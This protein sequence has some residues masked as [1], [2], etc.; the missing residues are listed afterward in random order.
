ML[1]ENERGEEHECPYRGLWGDGASAVE[2]KEEL[3]ARG[4]GECY[5]LVGELRELADWT[6]RTLSDRLLLLVERHRT[7]NKAGLHEL[8]HRVS[9]VSASA[10]PAA[11]VGLYLPR[12]RT[13]LRENLSFFWERPLRGGD[14]EGLGIDAVAQ[15]LPVEQET[16]PVRNIPQVGVQLRHWDPEVTLPAGSYDAIAAL[17]SYGLREAEI[18]EQQRRLLPAEESPSDVMAILD[19][20]GLKPISSGP[21]GPAPLPARLLMNML[22]AVPRGARSRGPTPVNTPTLTFRAGELREWCWPGSGGQ[23]SSGARGWRS[24]LLGGLFALDRLRVPVMEKLSWRPVSIALLLEQAADMTAETPVTV[25]FTLLPDGGQGPRV[26]VPTLR[27]LQASARPWRAYL[28]LAAHWYSGP[29]AEGAGLGSRGG[30][31]RW[32][33]RP[34]VAEL[35]ADEVYRL[36]FPR[37]GTEGG[38]LRKRRI[39]SKT[40]LYDLRDRGLLTLGEIFNESG[41]V[42]SWLVS[43]R[44]DERALPHLLAPVAGIA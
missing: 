11:E 29:K 31:G 34:P 14:V 33:V 35:S 44:N 9:V 37:D 1:E 5:R 18:I 27:E 39:D 10:D 2:M 6:W 38:A 36:C 40:T 16:A 23:R 19:E 30:V 8:E 26:H 12:Q 25:T 28:S 4:C 42:V 17:D 3:Q 20:G 41:Q 32:G 24:Q 22:L 7:E 15:L 21:R 13:E 43:P